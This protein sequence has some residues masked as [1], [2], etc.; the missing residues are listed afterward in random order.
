MEPEVWYL[1]E[2]AG[3]HTKPFS[4]EALW[5]ELECIGNICE[6]MEPEVWYL[7]EPK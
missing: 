6:L 1:E 2:S 7:E 4:P 3:K 5:I